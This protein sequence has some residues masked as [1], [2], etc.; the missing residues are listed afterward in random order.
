MTEEKVEFKNSRGEK[1][2]GLFISPK[3]EK[4]PLIVITHGFGG[5]TFEELFNKIAYPLVEEGFA[6]FSFMFPGYEPSEG[7]FENVTVENEVETLKDVY[8]FI[9]TLEIDNER[10]GSISQSLGCYVTLLANLPFKCNILISPAIDLKTSFTREF[11]GY[12][13][14]VDL[15]KG[16]D[17]KLNFGVTIYSKFWENVK[18]HGLFQ[19]FD[20]IR[21]PTF[22]IFG[23]KDDGTTISEIKEFF[24]SLPE[25]RKLE[26]LEGAEHVFLKKDDY[27]KAVVPPINNWFKRWLK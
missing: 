11:G 25:P 21:Q 20:R 16:N 14:L 10:I 3:V 19:N 6:I 5:Y 22:I 13:A 7:K 1:I 9:K 18:N 4:P 17:V 23:D 8:E 15:E 26:I 12:G 24:D 27:V 2:A